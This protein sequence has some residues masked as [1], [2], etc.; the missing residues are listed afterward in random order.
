MVEIC[1]MGSRSKFIFV[2]LMNT[3]DKYPTP[4]NIVLISLDTSVHEK[5]DTRNV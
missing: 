5:G 4:T 1:F 3:T 2:G